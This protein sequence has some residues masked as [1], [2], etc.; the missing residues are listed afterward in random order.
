MSVIA[1]AL[2]ATAAAAPRVNEECNQGLC[3][4]GLFCVETR[5]GKKK[6]AAC[7]QSKLNSLT[8]NVDTYCKAF[9]SG[10]TPETSP[11]YQA[12]L[13]EDGR[14]LVDVFDP[15]LES[16]KKCKEAREY[17]ENQC[18]NGGDSEHK[19]AIEDIG[20]SIDRISA[21]KSRMISDRR[22]YYGSKSDYQ[23]K[24]STFTAKCVRDANFPDINQKLDI[25]N[26]DQDKKNKVDCSDLEKLSNT[27]ERCFDAA[28]DL[29]RYG[30]ADSSSKTP[31]EYGKIHATAEK[32]TNKAKELLKT[33]K[34][35]ELCK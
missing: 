11:D 20:K 15:M 26:N 8:S 21:H 2:S 25:A 22:V 28:K 5:G 31:D 6:C 16:A 3:D 35:K 30:F 17:R 9:G 19:S 27:S 32:T 33:V 4:S 24:L 1:L 29:L 12:A 14:V 10:W 13:A 23:S 7:D 34:S 18:W